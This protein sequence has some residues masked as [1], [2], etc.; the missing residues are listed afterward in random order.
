[1]QTTTWER[2]RYVNSDAHHHDHL[3]LVGAFRF[4]PSCGNP[5]LAKD[6]HGFSP[7]TRLEAGTLAALQEICCSKC[8]LP[9]T[10]CPCGIKR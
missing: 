6:D 9:W 5:V 2:R 3:E 8:Y 7:A 1:M 4:C 10:S